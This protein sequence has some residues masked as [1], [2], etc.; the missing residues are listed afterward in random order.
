VTLGAFLRRGIAVSARADERARLAF[1]LEAA[2][3]SARLAAAYRLTLAGRR[4]GAA[5]TTRRAVLKPVRKLVGSPRRSFKVRVRVTAT[6][7]AGNARTSSRLVTV[8]VP[9]R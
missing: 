5:T 8:A 7:A 2:P 9:R 1:A 3:R 4:F 6:D